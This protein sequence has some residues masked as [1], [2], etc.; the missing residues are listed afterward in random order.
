[1]DDRPEILSG[2]L[3]WQPEPALPPLVIGLPALFAGTL[4]A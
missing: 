4:A 2:R 1:M 3:E